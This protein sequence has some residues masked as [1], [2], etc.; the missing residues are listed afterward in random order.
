[1]DGWAYIMSTR[2]VQTGLGELFFLK[3]Q[4]A[5]SQ[6]GG[7][8]ELSTLK[9]QCMKFSDDYYNYYMFLK[10]TVHFLGKHWIFR[11]AFPSHPYPR[12]LTSHTFSSEASQS[13]P[14]KPSPNF[15]YLSNQCPGFQDL[16]QSL[17]PASAVC[18]VCNLNFTLPLG[19][20]GHLE[21]NT[22]L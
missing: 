1:M 19:L 13:L 2:A 14:Q 15:D 11:A 18:S 17:P 9:I 3:K 10:K 7:G 5:Q 4:K 16:C 12:T 20:S 8:V 22:L 6:S 21:R